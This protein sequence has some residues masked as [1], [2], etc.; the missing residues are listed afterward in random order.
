MSIADIYAVSGDK[1]VPHSFPHERHAFAFQV[2]FDRLGGAASE[3]AIPIVAPKLPLAVGVEAL[4]W[5]CKYLR[6]CFHAGMKTQCNALARGVA[7][8]SGCGAA[9]RTSSLHFGGSRSAWNFCFDSQMEANNI[10]T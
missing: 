10:F 6:I 3:D 7:F 8:A 1:H 5:V 4:G 9:R 2:K